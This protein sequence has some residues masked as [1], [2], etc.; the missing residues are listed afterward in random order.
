MPRR[1]SSRLRVA[2]WRGRLASARVGAIALTALAG[3]S[4]SLPPLDRRDGGAIRDARSSDRG[5]RRDAAPP[6]DAGTPPADTRV[7]ARGRPDGRPADA[8]QQSLCPVELPSGNEQRCLRDGLV[9]EYGPDP[10]PACRPTATC[11]GGTWQLALPRC[12]PP[13]E[14]KCPETRSEAAGAACTVPEAYCVYA[15]LA[16]HCTACGDL[17]PIVCVEGDPIWQCEAPHA[18][19]SCPAARPLL[20]GLCSVEGKTCVYG[21]GPGGVRR[22]SA[23]AWVAGKDTICPVS[24]RRLKRDITYLSAAER[25]AIADQLLATRL[26]TYEYSDPALRG[27]RRLGFILEDQQPQSFAT[28][29]EHDQVDLYGYASMLVATAQAQQRQIAQLQHELRALRATTLKTSPAQA[30]CPR[31]GAR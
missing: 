30:V 26:A 20:G 4:D 5:A 1:T 15:G 17:G 22:C 25:A 14:A 28:D 3:C 11:D 16:C 27:R 18:D 23:G 2:R 9:C 29:A 31:P 12:L 21:C 6:S 24:S 7:D 13:P 8:A 19:P 10:R